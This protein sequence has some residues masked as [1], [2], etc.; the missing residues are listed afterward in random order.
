MAT[1]LSRELLFISVNVS[2]SFPVGSIVEYDASFKEI[3]D[4]PFRVLFDVTLAT[5]GNINVKGAE[6]LEMLVTAE[7]KLAACSVG[8]S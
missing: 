3:F 5:V 4:A 7:E 1:Y 8:E 6:L 2:F